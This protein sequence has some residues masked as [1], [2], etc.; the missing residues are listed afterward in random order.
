LNEEFD[1]FS[2]SVGPSSRAMR[3]GWSDERA[4]LDGPASVTA[5]VELR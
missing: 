3:G 4:G 5:S 1:G 2:V